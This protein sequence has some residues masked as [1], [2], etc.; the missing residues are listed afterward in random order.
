MRVAALLLALAALA[1]A[2]CGG[3]DDGSD[4]AEESGSGAATKPETGEGQPGGTTVEMNDQLEFEPREITVSSGETVTWTNVGKVAHTVTADKS[5]AADP[6]NVGLPPGVDEFD[7]GFIAEGESFSRK[8]DR[9][10]T[11]R[12]FCIPHEGAGM[13]GTVVVE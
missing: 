3:D 10:G 13:V 5:K 1:V 12:Y 11:Y 4:A 2:G 7:S 6:S 9:P 8:F